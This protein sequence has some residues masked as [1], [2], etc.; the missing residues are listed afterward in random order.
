ML[1]PK[2]IAKELL[3]GLEIM[4]EFGGIKIPDGTVDEKIDFLEWL[5]EVGR[6]AE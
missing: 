4:L 1:D 6:E 5:I 3:P 2:E